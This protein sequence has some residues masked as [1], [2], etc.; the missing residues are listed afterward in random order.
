MQQYNYKDFLERYNKG[1]LKLLISSEMA[2]N[3][4][5]GPSKFLAVTNIKIPLL[6][7]ILLRADIP[8]IALLLFY[9][10]FGIGFSK[11]WWAFFMVIFVFGVSASINMRSQGRNTKFFIIFILSALTF[12]FYKAIRD[13]LPYLIFL[14]SSLYFVVSNEITYRFSFN[15][16]KEKILKDENFYKFALVKGLCVIEEDKKSL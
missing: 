14:L 13:P 12:F 1:E 16:I 7:K 8:L 4:I 5:G 10:I 15:K 2:L 3:I 9:I 11:F 6:L